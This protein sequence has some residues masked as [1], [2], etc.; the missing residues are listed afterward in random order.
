MHADGTGAIVRALLRRNPVRH[1]RGSKP[2]QW[3]VFFVAFTVQL[4]KYYDRGSPFWCF[5]RRVLITEAWRIE[6]EEDA[7]RV[8]RCS[9][10]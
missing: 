7:I 4:A 2:Q 10:E 3:R 9:V 6:G 5:D 8:F 1:E